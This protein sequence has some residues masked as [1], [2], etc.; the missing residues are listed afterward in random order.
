MITAIFTQHSKT[1]VYGLTQ[2][3]YGR[4]LKVVA[5]IDIPDRTEVQF[6]QDGLDSR[7]Y[8]RRG[9]V[10]IPDRML[11]DEETITAYIYIR[12]D[13]SGETILTACLPITARPRPT[14]YIMQDMEEYQRLLPPGGIPGQV[15]VRQ[16]GDDYAIDWGHRADGVVYKDEYLQLM[17]GNIPVGERVRIISGTG[18]EIEL[19][20][21]GINIKWR[22]TDSNEW[23]ILASLESLKGPPG[24]VP[25]FEVRDGNL[26]AIYNE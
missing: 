15:P 3:D 24:E 4:M 11:Q 6:Y 19:A 7:G 21:D 10:R 26:Y 22:Y 5:D 1:T 12:S 13:T 20:N 14:D 8:L 18:R 2:W 23:A 25:E 16:D 9:T 17:S